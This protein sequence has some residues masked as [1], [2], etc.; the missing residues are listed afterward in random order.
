MAALPSSTSKRTNWLPYIALGSGIVALG[1]SALFVRW[2]NAP[3][4][5]VGF[6]RLGLSTLI[7]VPFFIIR[8]VQG[9]PIRREILIFPILG[10][11]L[12]ALDHGFWNTAVNFTTAANATLLANTAPLWVALFAW[13]IWREKLKPAFWAGLALTLAGAA[14]V[15][16]TDFLRRTTLG[17]GDILAIT[18]G[19]FYAG[20]FLVTQRGRIHWDTLSYI[21]IVGL[22]SSLSLLGFS[23]SMSLPV[24]GYSLQSYLAFLGAALISQTGGYL[25]VGYALGHLPASVVAPTMLG[26]PVVTA[27]LA[28]FFLGEPLEAGQL[29]G[30]V[31][32]LAGI[33]LVHT[34]REN[35]V[36]SG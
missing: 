1:F 10:G 34:S 29:L 35:S 15:L 31:A 9:A 32:V 18:A 24:T 21:W 33:Y 13:I 7:L 28:I 19:V 25:A 3:G 5:V 22:V 27:L 14:I 20:Y 4:P 11:V 12:T 36:Q 16:G 2:A 17:I 30:G 23:L 26:Q 8:R 6:Y